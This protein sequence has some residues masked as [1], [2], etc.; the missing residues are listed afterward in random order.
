MALR[1]KQTEV[2]LIPED[3]EVKSLGECLASTPRYGINAAAVPYSD[4]LPVYIR[5]TDISPDGRFAPEKLVSVDNAQS[6]NY[7]LLDGDIVL[8]RT[9][10][11]VGKSYKYDPND[12]PLV[13]AGFLILIRPN[14]TRLISGYIASY[15]STRTYW[16]WVSLMSMRSGQPGINGKEYSQLPVPVPSIREQREISISLSDV[17]DLIKNMD[18]LIIKKRDILQAAMQQLLTGQH[19]L[20]GFN[21]EWEMK[22]LGDVASLNRTSVVPFEYPDKKF[23]HF[24]LPAFDE[25][26]EPIKELGAKIGSNKFS[27]PADAILVSKLNPRIPRVWLPRS[28]PS[29]AIASTEFLVLTPKDIVMREFLYVTCKSSGFSAQMELAAT[30]TTG[31]HQRINPATALSLLVH[32]PYEKSEQAAVARIISDMDAELTT[33]EARR[34]KARQ[35]KQGMMQE[36]LTGRI[37]LA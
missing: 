36:L 20:P 9:G 13:F 15:L 30:G 11:S 33:L 8:A 29:N 14:P 17:D 19:R 27:V 10:A 18:Q 6:P 25:G 34:D 2:G 35:I 26:Q 5:I 21:G 1:Y 7:Y 3:W 28:I 22:R 37:R 4:R 16:N 32:V 23:T 24:S 31:S 12:G